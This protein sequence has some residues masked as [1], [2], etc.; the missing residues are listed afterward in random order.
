MAETAAMAAKSHNLLSERAGASEGLFMLE[1][2][3][4]KKA[5]HDLRAA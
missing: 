5:A 3:G 1:K 2:V 4:P